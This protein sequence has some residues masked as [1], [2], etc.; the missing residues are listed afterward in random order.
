MDDPNGQPDTR[1]TTGE[2]L[3]HLK[4][5]LLPALIA[6]L[7]K[8]YDY[9]PTS[10][11]ISQANRIFGHGQW[12]T[13]IVELQDIK[14]KDGEVDAY[15]CIA[16]VTIPT[17]G[18]SHSAVGF[19]EMTRVKGSTRPAQTPRAHNTAMKG[20]ESDAVKRALRY[21]GDQF[22]NSLYEKNEER[23]A[24]VDVVVR[25][26]ARGLGMD[27]EDAEKKV[28]GAFRNPESVPIS[29]ALALFDETREEIAKA[30]ADQ[31]A[32][33]EAAEEAEH[34]QER[35]R[36]PPEA[37]P[38]SDSDPEDED[39]EEEEIEDG[40]DASDDHDQSDDHDESDDHDGDDEEDDDEEDDEGDDD[41]HDRDQSDEDRDDRR[42][43]GRSD[44]R[45]RDDRRG[46][47]DRREGRTRRNG[48][49]E[50]G[51]SGSRSG[52]SDPFRGR[53]R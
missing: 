47:D 22:G 6:L 43:E 7:N 23:E 44:R 20:A 32:D 25:Y 16:R 9:L 13:E 8:Q 51:R 37:G 38:E 46:R 10:T 52:R 11:A 40:D 14:N 33:E 31:E 48:R 27:R 19:V 45:D 26:M 1:P 35:R 49:D 42:R 30:R 18:A 28:I 41:S 12:Q 34:A 3:K 36:P 15:R 29:V 50:G 4:R 5:P 21:L 24:L 53:N 39:E 17:L 2:T